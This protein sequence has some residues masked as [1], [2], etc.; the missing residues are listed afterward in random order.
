M[1]V[2]KEGAIETKICL[3]CKNKIDIKKD[4]FV[5]I[6]TINRATLPD[7]HAYFHFSCWVNY[8]NKRVETK[9]RLNVKFMQDKAMSLF[10]SPVIK[11]LLSQIQGSEMA[12]NMLSIP[13]N[14]DNRILKI[15]I[16]QKLKKDGKKRSRKN[17]MQ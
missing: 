3:E 13:L 14:K 5:R 11:G 4:N 16:K 2:K 9:V 15:K 17:K 7:D 12:L 1:V 8:F 6:S 10:H